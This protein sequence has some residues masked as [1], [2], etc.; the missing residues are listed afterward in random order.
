MPKRR[1]SFDFHRKTI[2]K[3]P[4]FTSTVSTSDY[5]SLYQKIP[6]LSV[7]GQYTQIKHLPGDRTCISCVSVEHSSTMP[8]RLEWIVS[9]RLVSSLFNRGNSSGERLGNVW[10][11]WVDKLNA[12]KDFG[13]VEL[14]VVGVKVR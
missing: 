8:S 7:L 10:A 13:S 12:L 5:D 2:Y 3:H 14:Q 4:T 6:E 11:D 9:Q 1:S